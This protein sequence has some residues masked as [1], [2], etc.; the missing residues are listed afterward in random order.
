MAQRDLSAQEVW[1]NKVLVQSGTIRKAES[2]G[3]RAG[4][5]GRGHD[6][7]EDVDVDINEQTAPFLRGKVKKT[8]DIEPVRIIKNPDGSLQRAALHQA[9]LARRE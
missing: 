7:E 6:V 5:G 9:T 2:K 4:T 8:Q 3:P 1:E